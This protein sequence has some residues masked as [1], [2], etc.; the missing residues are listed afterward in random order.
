MKNN[1]RQLELRIDRDIPVALTPEA[2]QELLEALGDLLL[3]IAA[4]SDP[5]TQ[6]EGSASDEY[7]DR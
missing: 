1:A 2:E 4:A 6:S 3:A 7:E 5:Q